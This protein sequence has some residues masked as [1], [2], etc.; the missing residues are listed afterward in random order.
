MEGY[1]PPIITEEDD[2]TGASPVSGVVVAGV[3]ILVVLAVAVYNRN[4]FNPRVSG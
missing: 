1:N 3:V 4:F 2:G